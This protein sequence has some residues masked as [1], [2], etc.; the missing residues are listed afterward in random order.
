MSAD[1]GGC[2]LPALVLGEP[3]DAPTHA[4]RAPGCA[5]PP[6]LKSLKVTPVL[7]SLKQPPAT[8]SFDESAPLFK[9]GRLVC[10]E[11]GGDKKGESPRHKSHAIAALLN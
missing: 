11:G 7:K 10:P 8:N 3:D 2:K 1:A 9:C 6:A 5:S 4:S